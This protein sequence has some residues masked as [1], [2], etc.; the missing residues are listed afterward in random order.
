MQS[1]SLGEDMSAKEDG[2]IVDLFLKQLCM[3]NRTARALLLLLL[4]LNCMNICK[5]AIVTQQHTQT[6][7]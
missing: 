3:R 7:T 4:S 6:C 1:A 5:A 2:F